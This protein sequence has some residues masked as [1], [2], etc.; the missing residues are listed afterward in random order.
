MKPLPKEPDDERRKK[1]KVAKGVYTVQDIE[2][3]HLSKS[4][5]LVR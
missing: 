5:F 3:N 4:V 1:S 2:L